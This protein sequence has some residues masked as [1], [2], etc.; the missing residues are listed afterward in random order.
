MVLK[1]HHC[2]CMETL[3]R[4]LRY[5]IRLL[6]KDPAFLFIAILVLGVGIGAN[7]AIFSIVNAVL[8]RPLPYKNSEKILLLWEDSVQMESSVAYPNYLDW[9]D[10][11]TTFESM[12]AFRKD[13]FNL[14][15]SNQ[16]ERVVGRMVSSTFFRLLGIRFEQG[17]DFRTEEDRV[18]G[19]PVTILSYGLWK[20]KFGSNPQILGKQIT[21]NDHKF[22][23]VGIAPVD[24]DF[25]SGADLFVPIA[26]F[27]SN[28]WD[29][30]S[31]PGIYVL[32][33][34]KP[35]VTQT[36]IHSELDTIAR[37]LQT[38]YPD[39]NSGRSILFRSLF[40]DVVRDSRA[41]LW[42]L[43]GA[44]AFVLLIASVNVANMLVARMLSRQKEISIRTALGAGRRQLI[45]Q[46]LT[47]SVVVAFFGGVIGI[48][49]ASWGI[50]LLLKLAPESLPRLKEIKMDGHVL[51]FTVVICFITG[52]LFGLLPAIHASRGNVFEKLK[53][54]GTQTSSGVKHARTRNVLIITELAIALILLIGTGLMIRSFS[55]LLAVDPGF[56]PKHLLT[57]QI[58]LGDNKYQGLK[59]SDFFT[60]LHEKIQTLPGVKSNA[61]SMGMP[62]LGSGEEYFSVEGRP[63]PPK[64]H[65]PE[66]V[67]YVVSP[68]YFQTM[69]IQLKNGR[70]FSERD[71]WKAPWVIVID[72]SLSRTFFPNEN[73]LGKKISLNPEFPP[74]EIVGVVAHVRHYSLEG[75]GPVQPQIY[76]AFYQVPEQFYSMIGPRMALLVRTEGNPIDIVPAIKT[77]IFEIDKNQPVFNVQTM[78]EIFS[79]TVATRQLITL[80]LSVFSIFALMLSA[81]GLYGLMSYSVVQRTREIGIRMAMGAKRSEILFMVIRQAF[82]LVLIGSAAGL[83]GSTALSRVLTSLLFSVAPTDLI[84][85]GIAAILLAL[86]AILASYIPAWKATRIDPITALRYE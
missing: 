19:N 39:T 77:K 1:L 47:E 27:S 45:Q 41:A 44:V 76:M 8:L 70:Y 66:A 26:Q 33:L 84:S 53:E 43:F 37:R 15:G 80:L 21:L 34:M 65:E 78:E 72:D 29:R 23:V 22:T 36:M 50:D 18:G 49:L 73:P 28:H 35:G 68:D 12:A 17:R 69:G 51:L 42:I 67:E 30:G 32:A 57:M 79:D 55:K 9:R 48:V 40:E 13:N 2:A 7:T 60:Q 38:K 85:F 31:H 63:K 83:L 54:S 86:V 52:I 81:V 71:N 5:S 24:F 14:S 82:V 10:Q 62:L 59:V 74:L 6:W 20:R 11:N 75:N 3:W 25:G 16:P 64:G 56:N 4:D 61:F 46:L 58:S